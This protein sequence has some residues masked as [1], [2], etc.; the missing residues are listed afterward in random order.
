MKLRKSKI[1][2]FFL[3]TGLVTTLTPA[4]SQ[5]LLKPQITN[6]KLKK[7]MIEDRYGTR[8]GFESFQL[9]DIDLNSL[10]KS[11]R[12]EASFFDTKIIVIE[13]N[14]FVRSIKN[15]SWFGRSTDLK[16]SI[17]IS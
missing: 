12:V 2:K 14:K 10:T 4:I 5:M 6:N 7:N 3:V 9:I 13:T 15:Y 17:M 11:N 8:D 16:S 1:R